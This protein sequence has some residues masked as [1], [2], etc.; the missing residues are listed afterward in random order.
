MPE[1]PQ[2]P[3]KDFPLFAHRNGQWAKKIKGVLRYFGSWREDPTGYVALAKYAEDLPYYLQGEP[4][5]VDASGITVAALCQQ[6]LATRAARVDA[7]DLSY[8]TFGHYQRSCRRMIDHFGA[9]RPIDTLRP[10]HF[11]SFKAG[12]QANGHTL[13]TVT[14]HVR[15]VRIVCK[16]AYDMQ[17]L[18]A[19]MRFGPEFREPN[20]SA[21]RRD[22]ASKIRDH[23][24]QSLERE[25]I[26]VLLAILRRK[27]Q[28]RAMLLLAINCGFGQSDCATLTRDAAKT[29]G[30][31]WLEFARVKTGVHRRCALWPETVEALREAMAIDHSHTDHPQLVFIHKDGRPWVFGAN[32]VRDGVTV[33]VSKDRIGN[34]FQKLLRRMGI[35]RR[36]VSFYAGRRTFQT[37]GDQSGDTLATSKIM[38]HVDTSMGDIYRQQFPDERLLHVSSYVRGWLFQ[39]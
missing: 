38:G 33:W 1:R 26:L 34:Q 20:Q 31:G 2:K 24:T 36:G 29:I 9:D 37:I 25:E 5:P 27:P 14:S 32:K 35:K 13:S 19:P 7:G 10:S 16:W 8:Q 3:H 21:K 11:A 4:P 15:S 17:M 30:G 12:L 18:D 28:L 6:F 22:K 39:R 23:G